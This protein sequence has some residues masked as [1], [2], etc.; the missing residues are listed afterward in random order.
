[1]TRTHP[2]FTRTISLAALAACG[3]AITAMAQDSP[4][5]ETYRVEFGDTMNRIAQSCR[6]SLDALLAANPDVDPRDLDV[7]A[8]LQ[9]PGQGV[10]QDRPDYQSESDEYQLI[11]QGIGAIIESA[12]GEELPSAGQDV[13]A[14][15]VPRS[16][17]PGEWVQ[18]AADGFSS[19]TRVAIGAGRAESEYQTLDYI[20]ASNNGSVEADVRVPDWADPGDDLIFVVADGNLKARSARFDVT[21]QDEAREGRRITA[22]GR[23]VEGVECPVL[24]SRDGRTFSLTGNSIDFTPGETVRVT[25]YAQGASICQQGLTLDVTDLTEIPGG[26]DNDGAITV[27]GEVQRGVEC[28]ILR[29]DDGDVYSLTGEPEAV[30][31]GERAEVTGETGG[32]SFCMQGTPLD[33]SSARKIG[34]GGTAPESPGQRAITGKLIDAYRGCMTLRTDD[35]DIWKLAD[36]SS[37]RLAGQRVTLEGKTPRGAPCG[38]G[39]TLI[40]ENVDVAGTGEGNRGPVIAKADI[41]GVWARRGDSCARPDLDVTGNAAGG[42][43]VET[44]LNRDPRTGYV[45]LGDEPAFVFDQPSRVFDLKLIADD[46]LVV[47]APS[48]ALNQQV[49]GHDISRSGTAFDRCRRR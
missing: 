18:V 34:G 22:E 9:I 43:V 16:G 2:I 41:E 45:R 49:G 13:S 27:R 46:R 10:S 35:N 3:A 4:C 11:A 28:K 1:M 36:F 39:P 7:S 8:R 47:Y 25:G 6:V 12:F 24:S 42:L 14:S 31:V 20:R 26:D 19:N 5:G 23:I 38:D 40:V 17:A 15:V 29:T 33:V 44:S 32:M 30:D 48:S 37:D 21:R